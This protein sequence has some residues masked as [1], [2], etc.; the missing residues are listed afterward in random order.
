MRSQSLPVQKASLPARD[1]S[2]SE[3]S[4]S[5][6]GEGHFFES[7]STFPSQR[8]LNDTAPPKRSAAEFAPDRSALRI[9]SSSSAVPRPSAQGSVV[10]S[11]ARAASSPAVR[12]KP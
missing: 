10:Q 5:S 4:K 12:S 9:S 6:F 3:R 2:A 8:S 11:A 1:A 7:A